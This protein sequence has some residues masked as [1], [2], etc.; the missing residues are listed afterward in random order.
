MTAE[1]NATYTTI[2]PQMHV[3]QA[4]LT[5]HQLEILCN[6]STPTS[7]TS[8][9]D[10]YN[11]PDALLY[12]V[13]VLLFYAFAMVVLMIKYIR[14]EN[15][16]AELSFYFTE[17]VKRDQFQDSRYQNKKSVEA[18]KTVVAE[19]YQPAVPEYRITAV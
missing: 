8:T 12:I 16:E 10:D 9:E 19:L 4:S 1:E 13:V 14:R 2:L 7:V 18:M 11:Q 6:R 3:T 5:E 15:Q 17:F